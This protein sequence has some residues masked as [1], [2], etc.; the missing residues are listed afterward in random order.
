VFTIEGAVVELI[1][2]ICFCTV[3]VILSFSL[4]V[5]Y[6]KKVAEVKLGS[7][8]KEAESIKK[9]AIKEAEAAGKEII[10][11]AKEESIK[12]K[13]KAEEEI[14]KLKQDVTE[15][16][17][18]LLQKEE[19]VNKRLETLDRKEQSLED[20]KTSLEKSQEEMKKLI[21]E[22]HE[23]IEKLSGLTREEAK[24]YL[25]ANVKKEIKREMAVLIREEEMKAKDECSKKAKEIIV[26]AMQRCSVEYV[27]EA[28]VSVVQ[29]PNDDMKGRIIGREGRNIRAIEAA[30]G[31]DLII[32]DTPDAVILSGFDPIRREIAKMSLERL[33]NDG[34]IHP[35][36]IEESVAK[37]KEEI[38]E[39]IKEE[40]KKAVFELGVNITEP[41]LI[42]YL[43]KL[44]YRTSYGQNVLKHSI[45]VAYLAGLMAS[46]LGENALMARRAGLLH[47]IGK[48][49]D[50]EREGTHV[51]IGVDICKRFK[52]N[53]TIINSVAAHHGDTEPKSIIA[54]I[55][56][57]ADAISASRP[58]ARRE[59]LETYVK[60][61]QQLED[62]AKSQD[63]VDKV[64]A[65]QAGREVRILV[66]PEVIDDDGMPILARDVARKIEE[67]VEYPGQIKVNVVRE[68]RAMELAK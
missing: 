36:K 3:A 57:L 33:I 25:L 11:E 26:G 29:L 31:I 2:I 17:K 53:E 23:K 54:V 43:G 67:S 66:V 10:L 50:Y 51:E 45:E 6:R 35:T 59:T 62:I 38:E 58:G 49:V 14:K 39:I 63:G 18:R 55:I 61:L 37:S 22:E 27:S 47:D 28:T 52:E 7:A 20:K 9:S 19:N 13:K 46:E 15:Y 4:G 8:E 21:S 60:R 65:I 42:K 68:T 56:Q 34:R 32:D 44:K 48:S 64:F 16:E 5:I 1:G 24:D 30:T 40:G 41:E 12:T